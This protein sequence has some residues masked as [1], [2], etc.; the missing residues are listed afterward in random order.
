MV[1]AE[2]IKLTQSE[3][4]RWGHFLV[5]VHQTPEGTVWEIEALMTGAVA[6]FRS[7][8]ELVAFIRSNLNPGGVGSPSSRETE[9]L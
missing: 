2:V 5:R 1:S 8:G 4:E 7:P 9:R 6:S 3:Q